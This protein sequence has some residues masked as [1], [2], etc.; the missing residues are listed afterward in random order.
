MCLLI[1]EICETVEA[2]LMLPTPGGSRGHKAR[3]I[4]LPYIQDIR[5]ELRVNIVG[6]V[7][8]HIKCR[9]FVAF[10]LAP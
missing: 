2:L 3:V 1:L 10:F 6:V 5:N 7:C 8:L 9:L 4:H